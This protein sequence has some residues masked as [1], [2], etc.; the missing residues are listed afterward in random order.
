VNEL[1]ARTVAGG[2]LLLNAVTLVLSLA[3]G[4]QW[5]WLSVLFAYGFLARVLTGP[6]LSPLGRGVQDLR[7]ADAPRV[8]PSR[9][10]RSVRQHLPSHSTLRSGAA[11]SEDLG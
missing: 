3:V 7:G 1:A 6:T 4:A 2:V 8:H 9:D 5:L 10:L 11:K